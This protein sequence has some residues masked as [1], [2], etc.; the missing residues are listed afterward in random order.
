MKRLQQKFMAFFGALL[1]L[2]L[3]LGGIF[4]AV[5]TNAF[6]EDSANAEVTGVQIRYGFA[7]YQFI[8]LENEMYSEI[9]PD[10]AV[11]N[12]SAYNT[13]EKVKIYTSPDQVEGT[14]LTEVCDPA[15]WTQNLWS[16]SGLMLQ[17][18][19]YTTYNGTTVYKITIEAGCQLPCGDSVYVTSEEVTYIN[20][21]F[22]NPDAVNSAFNWEKFVP[23]QDAEISGVQVR[24]AGEADKFIV[25]QSPIYTESVS[26]TID[27]GEY[28][29]ASKIKV[30]ISAEDTEGVLL[31]EIVGDSWY[32]T[33]GDFGT[34][35]Y[36]SYADPSDYDTYNGKTIYKITIEAGCELPCGENQ[37]TKYITEKDVTYINKQYGDDTAVDE[38]VSWEKEKAV[39]TGEIAGIQIRSDGADGY[40]VLLHESYAM[41]SPDTKVS[42]P[43]S[44]NTLSKIK[45]FTSAEDME[46][47]SLTEVCDPAGMT[48]N[49][50]TAGGLMLKI[51]DYA[52]YNGQTVYKIEIE[53]GCEF[54]CGD[55]IYVTPETVVYRNTD[56]GKED[57][58]N[59][60]SYNWWNEAFELQ[61]FGTTQLTTMDNRARTTDPAEERWLIFYFDQDF[62]LQQDAASWVEQLNMLDNIFCYLSDDPNAE[63]VV[64]RDI[65]FN[66][67]TMKGFGQS[68]ALNI[69]IINLP[70][71][72]GP[73]MYKVVV[74]AGCQFP[75]VKDGNPG[76][77]TVENDKIFVNR[78][79]GKTGEIFGLYDETGAP[80]T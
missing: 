43:E 49:R 74:K 60:E 13:R 59:Q 15:W 58:A 35:L 30:Y 32:Y 1:A 29:T 50:W 12:A 8:V 48:Q 7:D 10:T 33:Y 69:N 66:R 45:I 40:I 63:P 75:Y 4:L 14:Y 52:T 47:I 51:K 77:V 17:I 44:Y 18:K 55:V 23:S 72:D 78:D 73:H 6:A 16:S 5:P 34:G 11:A 3:M 21:D 24:N 76:Y 26:G 20:K 36:L 31:S 38:A 54:V 80:R 27:A 56:Y 41:L 79:Y 22:G 71:Y 64:L 37:Y 62:E 53:E 9:N 67:A 19:D 2:C 70:E 68:P 61:N 28:N 39:E 42:D 65:Y 57:I 25:L 46:G